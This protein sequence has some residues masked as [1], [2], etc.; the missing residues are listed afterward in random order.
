MPP[1]GHNGT[2]ALP[3]PYTGYCA[4][5]VVNLANK[6]T[7]AIFPPGQKFFRF[8][9]PGHVLRQSGENEIDADTEKGISLA[10]DDV[11]YEANRVYW[12]QPTYNTMINLIVTG[13]AMEQMLPDNTIRVFRLD[14][15]V[16]VRA[17]SGALTEFVTEEGFSPSNVPAQLSSISGQTDSPNT[18]PKPVGEPSNQTYFLYTHGK[19][20]ADGS[21]DVYQEFEGTTVP[22]SQGNYRINPFNALRWNGVIGE[23][24]GRGKCDE[25]YPDMHALN[26]LEKAMLD[27]AAMAA[28]NVTMVRPNAGS[29]SS[30]LRR[31]LAQAKNGDVIVGNFEDVN[32]LQF[33]N[34]QGMQF[35]DA[36]I[37]RL[38]QNLAAAFLMNSGQTRDAERVTAFELRKLAEELEGAL[39]GVYSMLSQDQQVW[40]LRRLML[41]MQGQKKLP[42]F[43]EGVIEPTILTGLEALGREAEFQ[44]V[45]TAGDFLT[46]IPPDVQNY[47]IRWP[48]LLGKAF[49][50]M[51]IPDVVNSED[52]AAALKQQEA[53]RQAQIRA[54]S[55]QQG[56]PQEPPPE[57]Q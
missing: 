8:A 25:H 26:L 3:D 47:Y 17:P 30:N 24:Y 20:Q 15:Y 35:T 40:R 11:Q 33:E 50:G 29:G 38:A 32:M 2:Q 43:P 14:Q 46:R 21:W 16:V 18:T 48:K 45:A 51:G 54:A 6:I 12:R 1:E 49:I 53:E 9:I 5:L 31:R 39:G 7:S 42:E 19:L 23:D 52:E 27:G 44:R 56:G 13:N 37:D 55:G 36:R 34:V 28:R 41:Q 57:G 4:R 22:N 10:E